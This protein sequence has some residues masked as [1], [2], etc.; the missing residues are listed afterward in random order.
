MEVAKGA[1]IQKETLLLVTQEVLEEKLK[2]K[3]AACL[4]SKLVNAKAAELPIVFL[5]EKVLEGRAKNYGMSVED[6]KTR[7]LLKVEIV[8]R[9]VAEL[10]CA[11]AGPAFSRTTGAQ[12]PIDGGNDRVI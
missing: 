8:S 1:G 7:N 4:L 6:Y 2:T 10:A 3:D 11:L 5:E 12:I 9:D